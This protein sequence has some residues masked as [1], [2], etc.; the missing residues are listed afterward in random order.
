MAG[1]KSFRL[2]IALDTCLHLYFSAS[3]S[4]VH[5]NHVALA[6]HVFSQIISPFL[7]NLAFTATPSSC[8]DALYMH[9]QDHASKIRSAW[10]LQKEPGHM[11]IA[12]DWLG[13]AEQEPV[14]DFFPTYLPSSS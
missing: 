3:T 5:S 7:H 6:L 2:S 10:N 12:H 9:G 13:C 1:A 4:K 11:N 8:F 14:D